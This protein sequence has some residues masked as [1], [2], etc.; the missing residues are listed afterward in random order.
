MKGVIHTVWSCQVGLLRV[1]PQRY[2]ETFE[3][4][5]LSEKRVGGLEQEEYFFFS[6]SV[7]RLDWNTWERREKDGGY[8]LQIKGRSTFLSFFKCCQIGPGELVGFWLDTNTKRF[9]LF[10]SGSP[11]VN[12]SLVSLGGCNST[13]LRTDFCGGNVTRTGPDPAARCTHL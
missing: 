10:L 3:K 8:L 12:T 1:W 13:G 11:S 7:V 2:L 4:K 5:R 9:F 6:S